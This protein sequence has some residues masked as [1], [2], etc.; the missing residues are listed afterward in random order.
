MGL[1]NIYAEY[2]LEIAHS[3]VEYHLQRINVAI[4]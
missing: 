2:V 4:E 3:E 1:L